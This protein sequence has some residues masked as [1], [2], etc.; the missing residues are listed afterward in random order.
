MRKHRLP[1]RLLV[2]WLYCLIICSGQLT[3]GMAQEQV[4]VVKLSAS[5]PSYTL[6]KFLYYLEDKT[7]QLTFKE[8]LNAPQR[9]KKSTTKNLNFGFSKA[10]Y[11]LRCQV[12]QD[13]NAQ[14]NWLLNQDYPL[15]DEVVFYYQD[16]QG[17][18]QHKKNGDQMP[19]YKRSPQTRTIV[20]PLKLLLPNKVHTFYLKLK[21]GG[22]IQLPLYIQ[23]SGYFHK[24]Q[25]QT[26]MFYGIF[27]GILLLISINNIFLGF[28]FRKRS[29]FFYV[30]YIW[31]SML[32]Y[33]SLSGHTYQYVWGKFPYLTNPMI[34]L[35]MGC[36]IIGLT[37]FIK[38]FLNIT[39]SI[40]KPI[41]NILSAIGGILAI[42]AFTIEYNKIISIATSIV[43][44]SI[45][46]AL[47]T[48]IYAMLRR[49]IS[50]Q[51]FVLAFAI[52]LM[53][54]GA[55]LFRAWG[56][57][58]INFFTIHAVEIGN[59][60]EIILIA[61]AI[62]DR[63]KREQR[64]NLEAKENAQRETLKAQRKALAIQQEANENL[65]DKV[66]ERTS[67]LQE[68][69][70]ELLKMSEELRDKLEQLNAT[71]ELVKYNAT[72]V[73]QKNRRI[74]DSI[75]AALSIQRA[76]L[77]NKEERNKLLGE[78][79]IIYRPKDIVS[80]DF[81]W[82]R[83]VG[84][85]TV[86]AA[87]D[88]TGH[89]VPGA[90]MSLIGY[91]A[92]EKIVIGNQITDPAIA[93]QELN[94]EI[95]QLFSKQKHFTNSGMD[96]VLLVWEKTSGGKV[97]MVFSAAK[98]S[99]YYIMP[100]YGTLQ[101]L[102]GDN[103]FIGELKKGQKQF[104]NQE[105]LLEKGSLIYTGSDGITDQNDVNRRRLGI[106]RL[107]TMLQENATLPLKEQKRLLE[108]ALDQHQ[109]N[110][111]QRDDILWLGVKFDD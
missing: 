79:Y 28:V 38:Q 33:T 81:Y 54:V 18:W 23:R 7:N 45:L 13:K 83:Q 17:N 10:T 37:T 63:Y 12:S 111:T 32:L 51:Y 60:V 98:S 35:S 68:T 84:N 110:T 92:L 97:K 76:I 21:S 105:V 56:V 85:K 25:T 75:K 16:A 19:I 53:G 52:Y 29:Y 69:N 2:G 34:V 61:F 71:Q 86:L 89:G 8:V 44:L 20:F 31:G 90:F 14:F 99:L 57:L 88:C 22:T 77:P 101:R 50:A 109:R 40:L 67:A 100:P 73:S 41:L 72:L 96:I 30:L 108:E 93:L 15:I 65:E 70:E 27:I 48:G 9:F 42:F 39:Q 102:K 66:K 11:W 6:G 107:Q 55:G 49:E 78:H 104:T 46:V 103:L 1:K 95:S 82:T 58:P 64:Q 87:V 74:Q 47:L 94:R 24:E 5:K 26:D 62:N 80:G 43:A 4:P 59:I 36:I 3:Q 106:L 91:N